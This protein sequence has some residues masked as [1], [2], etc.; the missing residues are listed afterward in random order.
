MSMQPDPPRSK[1]PKRIYMF[2][3]CFVFVFCF[4][5]LRPILLSGHNN[6]LLHGYDRKSDN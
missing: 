5:S 6:V 2:F 3:V 4:I 1:C